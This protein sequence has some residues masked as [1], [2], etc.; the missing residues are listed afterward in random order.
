MWLFINFLYL[1]SNEVAKADDSS[2]IEKVN[3]N[4]TEDPKPDSTTDVDASE[5]VIVCRELFF[6]S[7][8]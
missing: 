2:S 1:K 6:L 8:I 3:E 7:K 5:K 4:G